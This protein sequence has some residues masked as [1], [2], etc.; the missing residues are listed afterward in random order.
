MAATPPHLARLLL[1]LAAMSGGCITTLENNPELARQL[2][3]TQQAHPES[4]HVPRRQPL[5]Q[6][7]RFGPGAD[8]AVHATAATFA[9]SGPTGS[10]IAP[11]TRRLTLREA[12]QTAL[13]NSD[14]IRN[15]DDF[16]SAG[17]QLMRSPGSTP[18]AFDVQLVE[19]S[20]Q[21]VAAALAAFDSQVALGV[22]WGNNALIQGNQFRS[23]TAT[24]SD[25]IATNNGSVFA[26]LEKPLGGG[27]SVALI[28]TW[29]YTLNNLPNRSFN[30][31]YAGFLRAEYRQPLLAGRGQTF[32]S[33]AG[34]YGGRGAGRGPA[35]AEIEEDLAALRYQAQLQRLALQ[36]E[37]LYWDLWSAQQAE[38]SAAAARDDTEQ[39]WQ[40]LRQRAASG[41]TGGG[42]AAVAEAEEQ[43]HLRRHHAETARADR[44]EVQARLRRLI[45]FSSHP[46]EVL[47]AADSPGSAPLIIDWN[48]AYAQAIAARSEIA[49]AHLNLQSLRL[50]R[51]AARNLALP[52]LDLVTGVQA[53]G[54]GDDLSGT[55][56]VFDNDELGWNAGLEFSMPFGFRR[57]RLQIDH[58]NLRIAKAERVLAAQKEEVGHELRHALRNITR[59]RTALDSAAARRQAAARRLTAVQADYAAGR[60]RLDRLL[61]AR[62]AV[63]ESEQMFA[64]TLAQ[65]NKSLAA[66]HYRCGDLL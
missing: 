47:Q 49:E 15:R 40:R 17:N 52:Q 62:V 54:S 45:G 22:Q 30:S 65:Y 12:V 20:G 41:L 26:R 2:H 32:T 10:H 43:F 18:S 11:T 60:E 4:L 9:A 66:Y 8:Q 16:L 1:L 24:P 35:L 14:V 58:L 46:D 53:N 36:V 5:Q 59:W 31:Q 27:G 50:Q 7:P 29:N 38:Q 44:L 64:R 28:P 57:E 33:I 23:A 42:A 37:E 61:T 63:T 48:D 34:P 39:I 25:L 13:L 21:G 55:N 3:E 51:L 56:G 19:T 6:P